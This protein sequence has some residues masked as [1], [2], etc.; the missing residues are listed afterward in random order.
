MVFVVSFMVRCV[1]CVGLGIPT[2]PIYLNPR[3]PQYIPIYSDAARQSAAGARETVSVARAVEQRIV[4]AE[5]AAAA[6]RAKMEVGG[7]GG[8]VGCGG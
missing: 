2:P 8:G 4:T 6:R 3:P 5:D 7:F 1:G